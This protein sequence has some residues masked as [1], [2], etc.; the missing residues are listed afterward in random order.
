VLNAWNAKDFIHGDGTE[1]QEGRG[2]AGYG[3]RSQ[4]GTQWI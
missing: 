3:D 1:H 4:Q 2:D